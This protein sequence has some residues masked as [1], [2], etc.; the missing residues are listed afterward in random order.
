MKI[1]FLHS[2]QTKNYGGAETHTRHNIEKNTTS[3]LQLPL[4]IYLMTPH[5]KQLYLQPVTP[6]TNSLHNKREEYNRDTKG[7]LK[8]NTSIY[9]LVR[10]NLLERIFFFY[11]SI[12]HLEL[13]FS[14]KKPT[15]WNSGCLLGPSL[16]SFLQ[17]SDSWR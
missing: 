3:K 9:D 8:T 11:Y 15:E 7:N 10:R 16:S 17:P 4:C 12:M 6:P 5:K 2:E 1:V 14:I 13:H